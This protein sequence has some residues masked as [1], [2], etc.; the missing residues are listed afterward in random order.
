M[1]C[2]IWHFFDYFA[3]IFNRYAFLSLEKRQT[4]YYRLPSLFLLLLFS[5]KIQ[6]PAAI[7]PK[8]HFL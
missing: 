2:M 4:E 8:D 1:S 5:D 7:I 6:Q 3:S